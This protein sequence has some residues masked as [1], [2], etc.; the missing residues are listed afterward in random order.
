[1][2][3]RTFDELVRDL[4][5]RRK[6]GERPPVLL[7]GAGASVDAGIGAMEDP[8]PPVARTTTAVSPGTAPA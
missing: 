1:M 8:N 3:E 7:L 6:L 2:V 5:Q 4:R